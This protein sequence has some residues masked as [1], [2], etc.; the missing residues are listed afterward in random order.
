MQYILALGLTFKKFK[1]PLNV[2]IS[3][4]Q[5]ID[6]LT[7]DEDIQ[8]KN[9]E[10]PE[11][12]PKW[13]RWSMPEKMFFYEIDE[14][15]IGDKFRF[16]V[17]CQDNNYTNGFMTKTSLVQF[18]NAFIIPKSLL[19]WYIENKN[20]KRVTDFKYYRFSNTHLIKD[21]K[22]SNIFEENCW[23]YQRQN[24]HWRFEKQ[25][26][27]STLDSP[28]FGNVSTQYF[29]YN[30]GW[31]GG[32]FQVEIDVLQKHGIKMFNPYIDQGKRHGQIWTNLFH[33]EKSLEKYYKLNIYDE[34]K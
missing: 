17:D 27:H 2:T 33:F 34:D 4:N 25:G 32:R 18:R 1:K 10:Q 16:A 31:I 26:Q 5:M 20:T 19:K 14:N 24:W 28:L 21:T 23:P 3:S 30:P 15:T 12:N 8:I 13:Y 22:T 29:D 7:I 6:R 9:I 11:P